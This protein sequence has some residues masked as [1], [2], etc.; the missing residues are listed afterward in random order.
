MVPDCRLRCC[1]SSRILRAGSAATARRCPSDSAQLYTGPAP[2]S[3]TSPLPSQRAPIGS[4]RRV[5]SRPRPGHA[6][7]LSLR[8]YSTPRVLLLCSSSYTAYR[9][10]PASVEEVEGGPRAMEGVGRLRGLR[11]KETQQRHRSSL[12]R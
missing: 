4:P 7:K 5:A 1:T 10:E 11:A 9:G 12:A 8:G 3:G 6:V 2:P